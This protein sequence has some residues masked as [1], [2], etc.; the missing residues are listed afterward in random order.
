MRHG[1]LHKADASIILI[2]IL[3]ILGVSQDCTSFFAGLHGL[4]RGKYPPR[5]GALV[6]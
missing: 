4:E 1:Y 2:K 3:R 5:L 6:G